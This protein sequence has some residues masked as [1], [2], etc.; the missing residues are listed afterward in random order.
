M[1]K[2]GLWIVIMSKSEFYKVIFPT[3]GLI[4]CAAVMAAYYVSNVGYYEQKISVFTKFLLG[5]LK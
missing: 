1:V 5:A 2:T 3:L 4:W